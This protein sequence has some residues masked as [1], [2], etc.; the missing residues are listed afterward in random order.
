MQR[1]VS[2]FF[3]MCFVSLVAFAGQVSDTK[4]PLSGKGCANVTAKLKKLTAGK[5]K[6]KTCCGGIVLI[7]DVKQENGKKTI[8]GWYVQDSNGNEV[9]AEK[10]VD[11]D[12]RATIIQTENA[13]ACFIIDQKSN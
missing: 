7:A 1:I 13:K 6:V 11:S 8:A 4:R 10:G 2:L 12:G 5:M 3:A 9:K